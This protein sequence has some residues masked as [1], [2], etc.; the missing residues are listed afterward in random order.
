MEPEDSL[1][2]SQQLAT[3]PYPEADEPSPVSHP[4]FK[5]P[6]NS[7]IPFI[8]TSSRQPLSFVFPHQNSAYISLPQTTGPSH[9]I[10]LDLIARNK[11]CWI[12]QIT[13][14]FII[15]IP[16]TLVISLL[17]SLNIFISLRQHP[18]RFFPSCERRIFTHMQN[19]RRNYCP[20]THTT[21]RRHFQD[22]SVF[23]PGSEVN[24]TWRL[25]ENE[26]DKVICAL[27][28]PSRCV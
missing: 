13:Q 23:C 16:S 22:V 26:G 12:E 21:K 28:I 24:I 5:I 4:V 17:L 15:H 9:L 3:C 18:E 8:R 25:K 11:V 20:H 1:R 14:H 2:C 7:T 27:S 6:C 19:N 10:L